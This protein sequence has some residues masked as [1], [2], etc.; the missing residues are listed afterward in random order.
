M[1]ANFTMCTPSFPIPRETYTR[2]KWKPA[3]GFRNFPSCAGPQRIEI[4]IHGGKGGNFFNRASRDSSSRLHVVL[5]NERSVRLAVD[6]RRAVCPQQAAHC[7]R[8]EGPHV[9]DSMNLGLRD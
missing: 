8:Y 9:V 6:K 2:E 4:E 5:H 1:P 3:G 7:V